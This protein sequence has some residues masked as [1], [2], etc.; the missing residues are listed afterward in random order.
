MLTIISN[1]GNGDVAVLDSLYVRGDDD[2]LWYSAGLS[3][4]SGLGVYL[5]SVGLYGS[6]APSNSINISDRILGDSY[7]HRDAD[8]YWHQFSMT[9]TDFATP[10][11]VWTDLSQ[12][13]SVPTV[14][15]RRQNMRA[16]DGLYITDMGGSQIHKMG[17][18]GGLWSELAQGYGIPL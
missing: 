7:F 16:D 17:V 2:G 3:Y 14:R 11:Y 15:R 12:S 9:A 13:A 8:H 4:D 1:G 5:W 10:G 6:S 18:S